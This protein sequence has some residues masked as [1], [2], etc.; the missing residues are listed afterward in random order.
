MLEIIGI[1][2]IAAGVL[3]ILWSID[4]KID[5]VLELLKKLEENK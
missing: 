2:F 1:C 4:G 5:E 3:M